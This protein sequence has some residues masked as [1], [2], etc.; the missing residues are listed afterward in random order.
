MESTI[1]QVGGL[2][3][4]LKEIAETNVEIL[5]LEAAKKISLTLSS[6][7]TMM[8]IGLLL[9][10]IIIIGSIG[11]SILIG[12]QVGHLSYGFFIVCAFYLLIGL[13]LLLFRKNILSDPIRNIIIDKIIQ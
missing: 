5:K 8:A 11:L 4:K 13:L 2:V 6:V 10:L 7:I 1:D 3:N 9:L 12:N